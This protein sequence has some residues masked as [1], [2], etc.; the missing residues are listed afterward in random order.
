MAK[1]KS[2]E[3]F[4]IIGN[5]MLKVLHEKQY[6]RTTLF[7]YIKVPE[8]NLVVLRDVST[9]PE[10]KLTPAGNRP[11]K[12]IYKDIRTKFPNDPV[13]QKEEK[14]KFLMQ[15]K[16][17]YGNDWRKLDYQITTFN[18]CVMPAIGRPSQTQ[19]FSFQLPGTFHSVNVNITPC[20][21]V[22]EISLIE[23]LFIH[24][25]ENLEKVK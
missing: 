17:N 2:K 21:K 4:E 25:E 22:A 13:K 3:G 18:L 8:D 7:L 10:I 12:E 9:T 14:E 23:D 1:M 20:E 11:V 16:D 24:Y 15:V 19:D 5:V 6:D